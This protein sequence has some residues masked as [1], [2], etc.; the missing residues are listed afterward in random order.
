MEAGNILYRKLKD[1]QQKVRFLKTTHFKTATTISTM[2]R[3]I[4]VG[5]SLTLDSLSGEVYSTS[6][7]IITATTDDSS[8]MISACY[9]AGATPSLLD[10]RQVEIL[11]LQPRDGEARFGV[12]ITAGNANDYNT[13]A[14]GGSVNLSYTIQVVGSSRFNLGLEYRS[15]NGG[16]S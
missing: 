12:A 11:R 15:I 2:T 16:T 10:D 9:L 14:G 8:D 5:F 6:R 1:L 4:N 7:A 3:E 13:L